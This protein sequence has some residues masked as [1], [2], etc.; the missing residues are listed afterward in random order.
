MKQFLNSS[1]VVAGVVTGLA[2]VG[3]V[4]LNGLYA[5]VVGDA[6]SE[7]RDLIASSPSS[8]MAGKNGVITATKSGGN[9]EISYSFKGLQMKPHAWKFSIPASDA[10]AEMAAFGIP[11]S[12]FQPFSPTPA[13]MAERERTMKSG[14]FRQDGTVIR[15]YFREIIRRQREF[16]APAVAQFKREYA[17]AS[18]EETVQFW[19][20][21]C[22][23][24]P[25]G[26][27][28]SKK[29]GKF[30]GGLMPPVGMLIKG[31]GDCDSKGTLFATAMSHFPNVK[32]IVVSVTGHQMMGVRMPAKSGQK[33]YEFEGEEYVLC[34]PV[35]LGRLAFGTVGPAGSQPVIWSRRVVPTND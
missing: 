11:D 21:F 2:S 8:F 5:E 15:P 1:L 17:N 3:I 10:D 7:P 19:L 9:Y 20:H 29:D 33:S 12:F 27:P 16:L 23:D 32:I 18:P 35:G 4:R 13:V 28:P 22:Q 25:Y 34:E 24:I 26:I 6:I 31:W 14:G 30:Y